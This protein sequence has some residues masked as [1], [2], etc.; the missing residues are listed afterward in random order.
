MPGIVSAY[1]RGMDALS[2]R[3]GQVASFCVLAACAISA[4][5]ALVRYGFSIGSNAWLE[6]QW[7]LFAATVFLGAPALVQLN[8]HVRV[9]VVYGGRR[10]RTQAWIDLLGFIGFFLPVCAVLLWT[11]FGFAHD[12]W[13]SREM[14]NSAGGLVRWPVKALIPLGFALLLAQGLAE[15][16]KRIGFL[17]GRWNMDL[18]YER[19]LQ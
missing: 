13:A 11:S 15:I 14:S 7:Y 12:A 17:T 2:R 8:E 5:V 3:L 19:P 18:H 6:I 16:L 4:A 9:D 10:P 1:I